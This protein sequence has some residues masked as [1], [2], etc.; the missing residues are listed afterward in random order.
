VDSYNRVD[1]FFQMIYIKSQKSLNFTYEDLSKG[2]IKT[3]NETIHL[4]SLAAKL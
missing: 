4:L 2:I 1:S 3:D